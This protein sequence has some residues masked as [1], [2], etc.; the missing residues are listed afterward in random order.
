MLITSSQPE[1]LTFA[2]VKHVVKQMGLRADRFFPPGANP[3]YFFAEGVRRYQQV[4]PHKKRWHPSEITYY[5]SQARYTPALVRIR[6]IEGLRRYSASTGSWQQIVDV[7]FR[8]V[9]V[10]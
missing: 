1:G 4:Y 6:A 5:A 3:R 2:E 9:R 10:S 7:S 8:K